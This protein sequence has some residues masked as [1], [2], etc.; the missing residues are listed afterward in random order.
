MIASTSG[1]LAIHAGLK[2][3]EQ[4]GTAADAAITTACAQITLAAGSWSSFAGMLYV[5]YFDAATGQ[6]QSLN[7]GFNTPLEENEPLTIPAA[8]TPSGRTA[9]VGGFMPGIGA[10][11]DRFGRL[12]LGDLLQPAIELA[13]QGFVIDAFM[14]RFLKA[15]KGVLLRTAAGRDV[16]MKPDSSIYQEGDLF[17]Q[18]QLA[19]TL[20]EVAGNGPGHM[21]TGPWALR[22]VEAVQEEGGKITLRDLESYR[23][24]WEPPLENGYRDFTIHTIGLPELG[25]VQLLEGLNL[26]ELTEPDR[27]KPWFRDGQAL[28]DFIR[29]CRLGYAIT[30]APA[31]NPDPDA[32]QPIPWIAPRSRITREAALSNRE[33]LRSTTW[34]ATLSE[35]LA[36]SGGHSDA[37]VAVDSAGSV[38]VVI[39]SINTSLWGS[40]GL[41]VDGVSVPDPAS[42]QQGM[43][44]K[45]GAGKRF[46]NIVNPVIVLRDGKPVLAAGSIGNALHECML[47]HLVNILDY[48]MDPQT[49]LETP[50]FWGPWWGGAPGDDAFQA[51]DAD[52]FEPSLVDSV[53]AM[54]QPLRELSAAEARK[55]VSYWAGIRL[56]PDTGTLDGAV[57]PD[58]NGLVE[59]GNR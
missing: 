8:P 55:R 43:M 27:M 59:A 22:F 33:R 15:R 57:S 30:Y 31:Y 34:E 25:A 52:A 35:E 48:G 3:M 41:F 23:A 24:A 58:F 11:H 21:T 42:F 5:V 38:A 37:I 39:H 10:L 36:R 16:F 4:G 53:R 14:G 2:A 47:E 44:A 40:T 6:V 32:P 7:A 29:I 46:P 50:K 19:E 51:I 13:E 56:N 45:A 26:L 9:M 12:P 28:F 49:S 20:R 18:P 17:R 54:G 1:A